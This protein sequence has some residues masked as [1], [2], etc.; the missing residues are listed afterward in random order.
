MPRKHFQKIIT[1]NLE[2][3][4]RGATR[5]DYSQGKTNIESKQ[6]K[7]VLRSYHVKYVLQTS[8]TNDYNILPTEL[9]KHS[10]A[11]YIVHI[12]PILQ[13]SLTKDAFVQA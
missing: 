9:E 4:A 1:E 13:H 2:K 11:C 8:F 12:L 7:S 6:R 10:V 3:V 5:I